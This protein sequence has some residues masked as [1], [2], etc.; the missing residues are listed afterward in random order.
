LQVL[1]I[2]DL[3]IGNGEGISL[4]FNFSMSNDQSK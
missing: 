2:N 4:K 1:K 3:D